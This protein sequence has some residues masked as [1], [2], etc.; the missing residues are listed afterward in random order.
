VQAKK[1]ASERHWTH[2]QLNQIKIFMATVLDGFAPRRI[3]ATLFILL[4]ISFAELNPI[5]S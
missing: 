4:Q 3:G 2:R 5:K 1:K